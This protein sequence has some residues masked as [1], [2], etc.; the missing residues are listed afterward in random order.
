MKIAFNPSTVAALITPPN[1][2]DITFDLRGRNIFARGVKFCGTDT[3]TWRDIKIN[4]VSIGSN[5]LDLRNGSNTTLTN[6]NG[7]VTINSTWRPVVDNLTSNSTTSSLSANQGRVLKSLIDGK[8]NSGHT[9]DDRYLKLTGGTMASNALIT[10]ADSGSWGTDKGPQGARGGLYWTGQSDYAK[11]YAEETVGDNLDLVIQFGDDNS[12]GLSIRNK[13]NTQTSYISAGGVIT[14]GTF[15]GNLDWSYITNKPS[16]YTPSTHTHAWNSLTHS[17]TTENQAILTN[18]KANGWKLYTLNISR[19]DNAANNAHSHSNKSVLD[20]ITSGLVNNWNIAYTFVNT[21]TGTDT[22]KVINKWDEIVNFLAGITEDNKLNTLLNNK[23]SVYKLADNTNVGTIKNN[24][25]YYSTTDAS[26]GTLTN[27]PFNTGFALINMTSYDG[28]DDLRRSRL[29]FNAYGEIKVSDDRDQANTAETWYNVLTSKNSGISGST[30]KL[31]GTSITVYSSGTADG[32]YVKKSGDTMTGVLTIDTTNFGALI[33]KRN[34]DANGASIQFRGKSSVYGYIGLNNSTKDKQFLRWSSDTSKTY[35]IL[36]TSSTYTSNGKGVINGTTI[37]QVDNATNSTNSTN[38]RKLVNWYSARP[39]SLN[40][41]FG[42]GSL[43]IFYATSSTTEGKPA[44]DSH[45]LHLAWDNNGGWDTQLAVHTRSGKVST[46]AQNSGTW[47][48]WKTLAFTTDIPS[49]LKNPYSLTTFGVVYDGSSAKTVTTSTFISQVT[50]GTSTITD[51]T[52]FITSYASNSGFAD[53]NAVNVPYK[54]KAIHLWEYIKAKT[55]SL[56]ATKGH[57]HD[58]RYLKLTGGIMTGTIYRNSGGSTISGRDHAIIRQTHAPGG[59]SWNPIACVDTETGTWTLG[60][61]SSGSSDTN[62]HFCFSTNADYN[63]GNNN[64][65]YVTL[66]NKVGTIAL[67]SDIPSSLKNPHALTI[68]LNG[69]SQGPYDGSAAKNI[70]ITPGSIGAATSGHNHDSSY[71]KYTKVTKSTADNANATPYLYNV[72]NEEV[73]SGYYKYWYIFNMGQ[74]SR[75]NFGTQIAMPYQDSLTDSELFIRSAKS[76]SWRTWRRILHSNNYASILDSRY[77]TKSE[78]NTKLGTYLSLSGGTVTGNIILK[79]G[80]SADMTYAGNVHPY[81]RFDNSDSSQNVSLI[82]TDYDSYRRPAGIKLVG[83]Q[84][85]EWFEAANIYAT[86]FYGAL[87][88]NASSANKLTTAR[89]IALGTDLRGSANFDGSSN[90]TIS[91]NINACTVQVSSTNGLPFKRIAHFETGSSWNDNALLLYISQGYINGSNGI[92]RVEFRTDNIS[93]SSTSVT[94]SAAVRWL[95]RNGYGLDSLYAGYYVTTSKAYIDIYL[96]TTGGYQ[97]TVIRVLQDSRGGINSNVQLINSY[98]Y[99][100]T[101]H[102]EAYNSIEAASTALYNRAYTR[103]VSGSDVGT[104]SYSN[105]TGSVHWNNVTNKPSV[106]NPAAHTHTVFKNNLMIKGTNGVSDSASIHLG[107]GD[108]DTGFKWISDGKCQIYANNSAV[109]EWTSGGMNWFKNPTVNGNKIWNAG[110]DGS[111]SGLD[112]D[113]LDGWHLDSIRKNVGYSWSAKYRINNWSR[114]IKIDNYSNILL[115]INFSQNSQASNHLYLISTGYGCGNIVQLG[116]NGYNSNSAIKIRLT[117]NTATSHNVEIYST[118]GYNGATELSIN[119]NYTRIDG[120]STITT[121][122][123]YTAGGGTVRKEITSSYSKIVA[124]LQGNSDTT[125]KLQTPRQINGTNFDGS[126]NIITSYWGTT[127]TLTIGNSGKSVNGSANISWSLSEIGAAPSSH[128]HN[129][130]AN[131][132]YGGFTKSGRLPISG[133]YQSNASESGGNAPWSGWMHLINCQHSTTSNNFALQIAASFFDNNTFKIRVTN[134]S[135]NNTWRDII[136]SGNIGSQL[137]KGAYMTPLT[138]DIATLISSGYLASDYTNRYNAEEYMKAA[139]KYL[140]KNYP[141]YS[142][143]GTMVPNGRGFFTA[144][145]YG[146]GFNSNGYP[147]HIT[148]HYYP[149]GGNIINCGTTYGSWYYSGINRDGSSYKL[150]TAR[151]IWGQSFDGTADIS[152]TL[153][154]VAHIQFSADNTYNIGSNS[155]AS[156]YIY[157]YWLG[158]KSGQK[159]ELGANNSGFGQGLCIDTNL[160][161][162]IGTNTPT[163]KLDV[164]GDIRATGQIIREA[165]GQTWVN[166]RR[167]ALLRETTSR[168][169][170]T[171]WSLKTTNGSWDFGEYNSS[172]WNN[173]PVLSYITDTNFNSGNNTTTYQIKFPLD[174]GTIALTKNIP[175]SLKSPYSLTLK[176]NGTTLAVYDGSSAK[177]VNFTYTN[178]GAASASHTHTWTSITDKLVAGNEFNIVNAGFNAGMWFNYVPINDRSKTATITGYHF[179][180]G[181]TGYTSINASGF[182]K[183]GSNSS[184]VLLGDGGHKLESSLNVA[185]ATKLQTARSI[186]GHSFNGTADVNG[187]IY[188]NNSNSSNGAIRLNNNINSNARIS[189]IDS[190]VIFNTDAAIRFGGT[191]WDWNVWA[192]LKYTHSNKTIYLGIADGSVFNANS[193]QS[194]G[195]LRFPGISNVYA[196]TFNGSLSGNASTATNADKLDGVHLSGIFTAFGNNAHNITATIGGVTKSFLVNWAADSDK[197]D[198]YHENS[199]L[200]YRGDTSTDQEATLWSQIGIKQYNNALP[201]NLTGVYNYGSVIS[202]PGSSSRFEI[203]ASHQSSNGNGLYYRSGWGSDKKTWLKFID[204]SNIGSQS[205]NYANSA[206]NADKLDGIHANGLLTALSNSNNGISITVGG[207]TK[208]VSNISVNYASSAGSATRVIVNQHTTNDTNYPLVW[209]NQSNT[210]S[211]TENQLYKSWSDLYYNPKNKRLTVG[212]SVVASSFVK[213]GGTSQQLLRADGGIAT[214]NWSGQSGQPSWL[215]GGNNQHSYYVYNPSNFRV[216]YATSS[217]NADTLDGEH[218]SSFVRAGHYESA[219]L[220]KLDTYSFIRSVNSQVSSTSP[221][222]DIGWYNVIQLVHRN[223][224]DDGP[225]YIGQI[226]LGMTSNVNDIFFRC[227]RTD[228]WKTIIHSN[229]YTE[230]IN[231]YYWANVKISASSSTT[232]SPT[233]SNLT[234]TSSIRMGNIYLQNTNEINSTSGI[235]LNY[236][237]SGNISLCYGGGKVGIGT[238]SPT[239][240][241]DVN[242]QMRASGFHHSSMNSDNYILLAG[243]GY[244]SFGG[245]S[246]HPVFLGYLNLDHGSDGTVS[247]SFSCLGYT[248][249]FTY[250]RGGNY[251]KISI[252]DT[253]HQAFYIKAAT[254][255]VNYSGG[256]M[257]TWTGNHRGAGAWWLHCYA[258]SSNEVR[259]KGFHLKDTNNDSWWGGNPLWSDRSG[260][261]RITVCIF[262]YVT[263]R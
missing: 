20:G 107:I 103:I 13:A 37:T 110:N 100:D 111:G 29:A 68:S 179:G 161:V 74:Y 164:K 173:I 154:G 168:G 172:G 99:S 117:E 112:A 1:N 6:T 86:T 88:G 23:L 190:Q 239:Y 165:L 242:G 191:S 118:Y 114:I 77:Y 244:K 84:G 145:I 60:H 62:F 230:Y 122:L 137:V 96:K 147:E 71:V 55:D 260:V 187:T 27:S 89:N 98:Y 199:F 130:A 105:S 50:E 120:N 132:N 116:A 61:L 97:G 43:R 160:N 171:L 213:R 30:I 57:N 46:R 59:S 220:N 16:S 124:N 26:S 87:S 186:W 203:Y 83:N 38:A 51:G 143:F 257:D 53:T 70:N 9:H 184:Y 131:E 108:S 144:N 228:P 178:V 246:S 17:S 24:G 146:N 240:K 39:T 10:F 11:L 19:W 237:N 158:A 223:G 142:V 34:D 251:C 195:S 200:R 133:F 202:L 218:A 41:Q 106:F 52:M 149:H 72:E 229:N 233:V 208:S 121:Y 243:G 182:I 148:I 193:A 7:V 238:T 5:I 93:S 170:H 79:G 67:L 262:G 21:I 212:G 259:V 129:Y 40:T 101:N 231:N 150:Q 261:N 159:L 85:N 136:H 44:E 177:E 219:D 175:T 92:C 81:I 183:K 152:G 135:I 22:D 248:V 2:K 156:R 63:A 181:A 196:T 8:S 201:D 197:L 91:A 65:N 169:Y 216:A 166:G 234:A 221:K 78:V 198:G 235:H 217:G 189:A 25:I 32:R 125:T 73:I 31:N 138:L 140:Q 82:F 134:N 245:D 139:A 206:G 211:V 249:P 18:G 247:S 115:A 215:W 75:G 225:N 36:D 64:G 188:I 263:F 4:N 104:V 102:K 163:Y 14:T 204:S 214:F 94:A 69:T 113:L 253:T 95:V 176:A 54:R 42:D 207:T 162:G 250:T 127:R 210:N 33:I 167:V 128:S 109:G 66:R 236:Q 205:V 35:T 76:G 224:D 126:A 180:N 90:I 174:S 123:T 226:A 157:T 47:Q 12:N 155:A 45:I 256:G 153:S 49:S 58:D 232:T 48:P 3:N 80:T 222:G 151:K 227:R 56:Y 258:P 141:G 209:S 185:S 252:P 119:C 194:G 254:A 241:L 192:G 15:K 28:G 255:S